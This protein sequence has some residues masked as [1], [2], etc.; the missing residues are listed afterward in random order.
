MDVHRVEKFG[1]IGHTVYAAFWKNSDETFVYDVL[2]SW[3]QRRLVS[4]GIKVLSRTCSVAHP[5]PG[6]IWSVEGWDN[7]QEGL[8][9]QS[10]RHSVV[11]SKIL[12]FRDWKQ[13]QT[14]TCITQ[15]DTEVK[16]ACAIIYGTPGRKQELCWFEATHVTCP[17]TKY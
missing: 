16:C 2:Q 10:F 11:S 4:H 14:E 12:Q 3:Q 6:V 1:F 5:W 8:G 17:C 9:C 7:R 13:N 15:Q